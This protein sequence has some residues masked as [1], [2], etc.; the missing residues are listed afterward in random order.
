M[1]NTAG[2]SPDKKNSNRPTNKA[3]PTRNLNGPLKQCEDALRD[4]FSSYR[5]ESAKCV[6]NISKDSWKDE[7]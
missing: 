3:P 5:D 2:T 1:S 6:L 7:H 4:A